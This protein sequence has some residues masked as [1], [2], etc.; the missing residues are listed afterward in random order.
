ML[1]W[2]PSALR[3]L[4]CDDLV[5][6]DLWSAS[7]HCQGNT[8]QIQNGNNDSAANENLRKSW[9]KLHLTG[10]KTRFDK[11]SLK[12]NWTVLYVYIASATRGTP[13]FQ[14]VT[15]KTARKWNISAIYRKKEIKMFN[16]TTK[17]GVLLHTFLPIMRLP[18]SVPKV[19]T[20]K[21]FDCSGLQLWLH[22]WIGPLYDPVTMQFV[23]AHLDLSLFRK[24]H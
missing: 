1:P 17:N 21:C 6:G 13:P 11:T 8:K 5:L 7:E 14:A 2:R 18:S 20:V 4:F 3:E 10:R 9:G 12:Y 23:P 24:S 19:T 15:D 16:S 22:I